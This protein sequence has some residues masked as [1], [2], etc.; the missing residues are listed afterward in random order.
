MWLRPV[1]VHLRILCLVRE[2]QCM[3]E[4][5]GEVE[6]SLDQHSKHYYDNP[7]NPTKKLSNLKKKFENFLDK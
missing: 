6:E 7:H 2:T 4:C 3:K 5:I 1:F